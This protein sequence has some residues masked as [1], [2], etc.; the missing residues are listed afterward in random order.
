MAQIVVGRQTV[1]FT[2][3]KTGNL[4]QGVKLF[5]TSTDSNVIGVRTDEVYIQ[6][7]K[8]NYQTAMSLPLNSQIIIL[9]NKYG[10]YDD[11]IVQ[12]SSTAAPDPAKK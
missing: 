2:D 9:R 6:S 1:E 10:K 3:Q 12:P 11:M 7:G 8:P 5:L 4:I